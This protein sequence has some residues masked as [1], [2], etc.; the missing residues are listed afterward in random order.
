M[1]FPL[2]PLQLVAQWVP[3]AFFIVAILPAFYDWSWSKT[4]EDLAKSPT[5]ISPA[6]SLPAFA[7]AA[8]VIG[9]VFDSLRDIFE[10]DNINWDFFF[11]GE[12]EKLRK[13]EDYYFTYYI[14]NV[15]L[16][17]A[18][19][20]A[21][22]V[23]ILAGHFC[24]FSLLIWFLVILSLVILIWDA[25][26]LR[27]HIVKHTNSIPKTPLP[28]EGVYTRL[29]PSII[30]AGGVGVFAICDIKKDAPIFGDDE[31]DMVWVDE[32]ESTGVP[33]AVRELYD[34]FAVIKNDGK[35]YGCPQSFNLLTLSWYLNESNNPNVRCDKDY[36]F[37]ALRDIE[38]GE[39]LTVN[40]L[41]YS[42]L[43]KKSRR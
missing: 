18:L 1:S 29:K 15:N 20:V 30:H 33:P 41:T 23:W 19:S 22:L 28:H 14:F 8:F 4:M 34:D 11:G 21:M 3:G 25:C 12:T 40:Y 16:A 32:N 5:S 6:V 7:I 36:R 37:F 26:L 9:Q 35:C 2:K 17:I 24:D 31:E 38:A 13:L 27:K 39:E 10:N 42:E 43:P